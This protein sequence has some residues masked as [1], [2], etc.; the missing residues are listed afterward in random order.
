MWRD[1]SEGGN[2]LGQREEAD[3]TFLCNEVKNL[4]ELYQ[5]LRR[6]RK[7]AGSVKAL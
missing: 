6:G 1:N 2:H 5:T 3:E 7:A 4:E